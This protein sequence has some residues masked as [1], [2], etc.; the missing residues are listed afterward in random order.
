MKINLGKAQHI[1]EALAAVNGA[2]T[3]HAFTNADELMSVAHEAEQRLQRLL[4]PRS[5]WA[6]V[7][8]TAF[9]G[10]PTAKAYRYP[11]RGTWIKLRRGAKDW[12]LV[13]IDE[14]TLH[15]QDGGKVV[16]FLTGE[17]ERVVIDRVKSQYHV[18]R[19]LA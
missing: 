14:V 17:Q 2:A 16:L 1:K 10:A 5:Y 7:Q 12:F 6:G 18:Y 4:L 13:G 3:K 15:P 11:R 19:G 8:V 9:S